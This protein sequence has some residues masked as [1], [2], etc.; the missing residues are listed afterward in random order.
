MHNTV[1][2]TILNDCFEDLVK[3]E[4]IIEKNHLV[5][6]VKYLT[7]YAVIKACSTIEHCF[8]RLV[9]DKLEQVAPAMSYYINN[10]VRNSSANPRCDTMFKFLSEYDES[11]ARSFKDRIKKHADS[12]RIK[13]S[14]ESL[15]NTRNAFAHT[16]N[17][18]CTFSDVGNYYLN[19]IEFLKI[20]D[21]IVQ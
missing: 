2:E 12:S 20:I 11:W 1:V 16:G 15:V 21:D 7:C 4:E 14:L 3:V 17:C 18:A 13:E 9:A 6:S 8:K 19:A 5:P 10:K